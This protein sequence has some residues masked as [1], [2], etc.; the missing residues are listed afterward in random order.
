VADAFADGEA[1]IYAATCWEFVG[2]RVADCIR[3]CVKQQWAALKRA[4]K[5]SVSP[6]SWQDVLDQL[7]HDRDP[8]LRAE[9]DG[10]RCYLRFALEGRE[11]V[12]HANPSMD[13][14]AVEVHE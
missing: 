9:Y 13:N 14:R 1:V 6:E 7:V 10:P 8:T 12:V 3:W 11:I 2:K 4:G 5:V